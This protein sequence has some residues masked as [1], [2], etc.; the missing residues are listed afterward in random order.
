M[1]RSQSGGNN[2][3]FHVGVRSTVA[4]SE[5]SLSCILPGLKIS[6]LSTTNQLPSSCGVKTKKGIC[7]KVPQNNP[8]EQ[9]QRKWRPDLLKNVEHA[10]GPAASNLIGRLK[11]NRKTVRPIAFQS[12]CLL[13]SLSTRWTCDINPRGHTSL[14][15]TSV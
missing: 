6:W 11:P 1:P 12:C 15:I 2:F 14:P 9:R 3:I 8:Q 5:H 4:E 7:C 13:Q 10:G